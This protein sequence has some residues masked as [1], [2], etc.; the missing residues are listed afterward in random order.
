MYVEKATCLCGQVKL[1]AAKH[2]NTV[3]ACHCGICRKWTGGPFMTID[4]GTDVSFD[5]AGS[6]SVFSSSEW[7]ERGFCKH[8]GSHIFY[9]LKET[10]QYFIPAGLFENTDNFVFDHQVFID[11]KPHYYDFANNAENMTEAQVFAMFGASDK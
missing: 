10:Q 6:V 9:R 5:S 2:N 3:G 11:N 1:T 4:C 8:C 7:A